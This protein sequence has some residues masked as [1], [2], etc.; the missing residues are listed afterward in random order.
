MQAQPQPQRMGTAYDDIPIVHPTDVY[1]LNY[2]PGPSIHPTP[3]YIAC[4]QG[5]LDVVESLAIAETHS[6]PAFLHYGLAVALGSGQIAV[7]AYSLSIGA[8]IARQTPRCILS[9]PSSSQIALFELLAQH[10]WTPNTPGFYG[11]V[12]LPEIVTNHNLLEWFLAHGADPNLGPQRDYRDRL[13]GPETDSCAALER[14]ARY[15][16]ENAVRHLLAAG[17]SI[18][19]GAPLH[20]AA[21]ALSTDRVSNPFV[22]RVTPSRDFDEKLIPTMALLVA[23]GADVNSREVSRHQVPGLAVVEAV[24]AGA[25]Q[26]VKWLLDH[27]ADPKAKGAWGSAV[28]YANKLGSQEMKDVLACYIPEA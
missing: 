3:Y 10:G 20:R 19:N 6:T 2:R 13:G 24:M 5:H 17:A 16:D 28:D 18:S 22:G 27:G 11:A 12:L 26:R 15:G 9:A 21:G 23:H 25:V 4:Q 8:P 1:L 14:A 7:A